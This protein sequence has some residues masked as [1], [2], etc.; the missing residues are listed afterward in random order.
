[1][2]ATQKETHK[3]TN[4]QARKKITELQIMVTELLQ[5]I[6]WNKDKE[7]EQEAAAVIEETILVPDNIKFELWVGSWDRLWI[8]FNENQQVLSYRGLKSG[9]YEVHYASE[10]KFIQCKL[11]KVN[12]KDRQVGHTYYR[13]YNDINSVG[14]LENYCKY[15]WEWTYAFVSE[16]MHVVVSWEYFSIRHQVV[17]I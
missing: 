15:L 11:V 6:T 9:I 3:L 1:M 16:G 5:Y 13:T 17:P 2:T 7:E 10:K 8:A 4:K 12:P 14:K